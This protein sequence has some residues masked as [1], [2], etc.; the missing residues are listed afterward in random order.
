MLQKLLASLNSFHGVLILFGIRGGSK[1]DEKESGD[2][3]HKNSDKLYCGEG[4]WDEKTM[5]HDG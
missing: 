2:P 5:L 3:E 4:T 1:W